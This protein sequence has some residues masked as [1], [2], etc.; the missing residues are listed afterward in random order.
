MTTYRGY[1]LKTESDGK[2]TIHS[3][4]SYPVVKERFDTE[5]QAMDYIDALRR[6][7]IQS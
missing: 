2:I 1:D 7:A 4:G 3:M 6:K 5:E